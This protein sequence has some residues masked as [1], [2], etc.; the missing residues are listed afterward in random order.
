MVGPYIEMQR[1][2]RHRILCPFGKQNC[3]IDVVYLLI[4]SWF[5]GTR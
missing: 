5:G 4:H 3:D 2:V 1:D